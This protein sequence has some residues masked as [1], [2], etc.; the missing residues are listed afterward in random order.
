L[1]PRQY[2]SNPDTF[3]PEYYAVAPGKDT[4]FAGNPH[5][6]S[7]STPPSDTHPPFHLAAVKCFVTPFESGYGT[8]PEEV[9]RHNVLLENINSAMSDG[10]KR[11][12]PII[13]GG[14]GTV[15]ALRKVL[16][17]NSPL[18]L[19]SDSGRVAGILTALIEC[20][21][22]RDGKLTEPD[23]LVQILTSLE[24]P[25]TLHKERESILANPNYI[26][27]LTSFFADTKGREHLVRVC[28]S[29]E[30]EE[31]LVTSLSQHVR[32]AAD[33]LYFPHAIY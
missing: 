2:D 32:I 14:F 20:P 30:L 1:R 26:T 5:R 7:D 17:N 19:V 25:Q 16:A 28:T 33:T 15:D 27:L 10:F 3:K 13:N 24:L 12:T 9:Q 6:P 8:H 18:L 31:T 23:L 22:F 29:L 4:S 21:A 11:V